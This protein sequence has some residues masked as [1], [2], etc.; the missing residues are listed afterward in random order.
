[1]C[2]SGSVKHF[3]PSDSVHVHVDSGHHAHSVDSLVQCKAFLATMLDSIKAIEAV[4]LQTIPSISEFKNSQDAALAGPG[5]PVIVA[6]LVI[7][8]LLC[9][10]ARSLL[11]LC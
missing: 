11:P 2:V 1:V 6:L 9:L 7:V 8:G 4:G 10:C 5:M 3:T